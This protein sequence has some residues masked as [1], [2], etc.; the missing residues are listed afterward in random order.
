MLVFGVLGNFSMERFDELDDEFYVMVVS[1]I[2]GN[3]RFVNFILK[4]MVVVLFDDE[5]DKMVVVESYIVDVLEGNS[6]EDIILFVDIIIRYN[7]VLFV[8]F[9]KKKMG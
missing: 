5:V 2:G 8:K 1:I 6:E 3:Y 7:F 4:I 9:M